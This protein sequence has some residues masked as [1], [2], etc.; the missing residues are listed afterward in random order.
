MQTHGKLKAYVI[1]A[2]AVYGEGE[3][4]FHHWFKS[5]WH[6][7]NFL[8]IYGTGKNMVPAIYVNDLATYDFNIVFL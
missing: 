6:N 5:A 7:A 1:G 2:G 3:G 4:P 8:P